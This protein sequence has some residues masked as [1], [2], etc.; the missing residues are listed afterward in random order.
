MTREDFLSAF[1]EGWAAC[2]HQ[3]HHPMSDGLYGDTEREL[4]EAA[5]INYQEVNH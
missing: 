5:W 2:R 4:A 3:I 1:E